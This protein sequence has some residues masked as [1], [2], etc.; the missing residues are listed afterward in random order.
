MKT[1]DGSVLFR[2]ANSIVKNGEKDEAGHS[3][4]GLENVTKRLKSFVSRVNMI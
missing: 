1:E 4:I 3:G 2:C